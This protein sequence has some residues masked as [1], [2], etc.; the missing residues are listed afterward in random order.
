MLR[1]IWEVLSVLRGRVFR[2]VRSSVT[3]DHHHR[4]VRVHAF[5]HAEKVGAV[6]GDQICE[7]VLEQS[8]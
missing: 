5:G 2:A 4:A 3:D 8:E 7:V 1:S 6:V